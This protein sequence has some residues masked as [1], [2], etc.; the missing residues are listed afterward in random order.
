MTAQSFDVKSIS[1]VEFMENYP[2]SFRK[3]NIENLLIFYFHTSGISS[4][5]IKKI[6]HCSASKVSKSISL[7]NKTMS[8]SSKIRSKEHSEGFLLMT[9]QLLKHQAIALRHE[10]VMSQDSTSHQVTNKEQ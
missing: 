9:A 10:K 3:L 5:E 7:V 4:S 2:L 6:F 8:D 1:M